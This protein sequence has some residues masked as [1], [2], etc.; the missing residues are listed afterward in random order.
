MT[1]KKIDQKEG[2]ELKKIFNYY[3]DKRKGIMK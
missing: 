1:D 3:L 2:D